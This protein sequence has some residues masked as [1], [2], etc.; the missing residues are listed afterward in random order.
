MNF[1]IN[2]TGIPG[3][4]DQN[5]SVK[6]TAIFKNRRREMNFNSGYGTNVLQLSNTTVIQAY[7]LYISG[8]I[9]PEKK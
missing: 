2:D 9:Y 4:V 7:R 6:N 5:R 1:F 8:L 3:R